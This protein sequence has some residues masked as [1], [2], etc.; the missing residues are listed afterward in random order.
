MRCYNK[1]G[2]FDQTPEKKEIKMKIMENKKKKSKSFSL[3]TINVEQWNNCYLLVAM[4]ARGA[5]I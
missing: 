2:G 1:L 3:N 5:I 4:R